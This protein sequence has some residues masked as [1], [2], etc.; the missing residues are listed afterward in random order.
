MHGE[1]WGHQA[2]KHP[3][4]PQLLPPTPTHLPT[5]SGILTVPESAG[6]LTHQ[7]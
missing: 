3:G 5:S 6:E 2:F 7:G 4:I 1:S